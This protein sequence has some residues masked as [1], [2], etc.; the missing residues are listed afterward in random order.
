MER[1]PLTTPEKHGS[2]SAFAG[3]SGARCVAFC[4]LLLLLSACVGGDGGGENFTV[5]LANFER[6]ALVIGQ[7]DFAG[8][9]HNQDGGATPSAETLWKPVGS[10]AIT[11]GVLYI[12]DQTNNRVL[13]YSTVPITNGAPAS[14]VLGQPDF[15]TNILGTS[16]TTLNVPTG[17]S[18][19]DFRLFVSDGGNQRGLIWNGLPTTTEEPANV[20]LGVV[21]MDTVETGDCANASDEPL[22]D[23]P[24]SIFAFDFVGNTE[25]LLA[26]TAHNRVLRWDTVPGTNAT[27]PDLV[28]GQ[29]AM[30]ECIANDIDHDGVGPD[31]PDATTLNGPVGIWSDGILLVVADTGNNRV[32]IWNSFPTADAQPADIVL[33]QID[34]TGNSPNAGG[35]SAATLNGPTAVNSNGTELYVADTGNNRV[36]GWNS[37]PTADGQAAD[38]VLG[39]ADFTHVTADDDDQDG[40][41]DTEPS[42][43]TVQG[44]TGVFV[45]GKRLFVT[46]TGNH[47]VLVFAGN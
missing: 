37:M 27:P 19:A 23:T 30:I 7:V 28:L 15:A 22:L 41:P 39:Q 4:T 6:A 47:R 1:K 3:K 42:D 12:T 45:H 26:D 18:A 29:D 24:R 8:Q 38:I 32:L 13:G 43:R 40:T 35:V 17:I 36:L 34:F 10:V 20:T 21:D 5:G 2:R 33:G 31:T 9:K 46:D 11:N 44:P 25:A 16:A 14:F